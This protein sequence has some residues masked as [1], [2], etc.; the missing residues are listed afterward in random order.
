MN[1]MTYMTVKIT[2]PTYLSRIYHGLFDTG[3]NVCVCKEKILPP[4]LW[5]ETKSTVLNGFGAEKT[6]AYKI[7][8]PL[9]NKKNIINNIQTEENI[10]YKILGDEIF[11]ENPLAGWE[12][13]KTYAKIE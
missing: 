3:A 9:Q 13:H 7:T 5:K 1:S 10:L 4:E 12:K 6:L 8:Q 2:I 11:N